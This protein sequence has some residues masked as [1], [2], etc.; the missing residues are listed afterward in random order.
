MQFCTVHIENKYI[1]IKLVNFKDSGSVN[2]PVLYPST[3]VTF[4]FEEIQ[5]TDWSGELAEYCKS[6]TQW[7]RAP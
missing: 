6:S 7:V 5:L 1:L 4:K 3:I 2:R